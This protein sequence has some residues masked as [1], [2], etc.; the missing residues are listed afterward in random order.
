MTLAL[1]WLPRLLCV[2]FAGF[3]SLFALDALDAHGGA[4]QSAVVLFAHLLPTLA[5]L[6]V[7]AVAWRREWIGA[8]LFPLFAIAHVIASRAHLHW[9]AYAIIDAPLILLGVLFWI[10]WRRRFARQPR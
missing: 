2:A 7:L 6:A 3:L 10:N 4:W 9:S 1:Y 5:V 8:V